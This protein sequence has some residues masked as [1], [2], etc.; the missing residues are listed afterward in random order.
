MANWKDTI[1]L[2]DELGSRTDQIAPEVRSQFPEESEALGAWGSR[3]GLVG[4]AE[5]VNDESA[6]LVH[7]FTPTRHELGV[8]AR[9]YLKVAFDIETWWESCNQVG[10]DETR[11]HAFAGRRLET[12]RSM[13][14]D[15]V[16]EQSEA[17]IEVPAHVDQ[18]DRI[19]L[20]AEPLPR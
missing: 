1:L 6:R 18:N 7:D 14:G 20:E 15:A 10:S 9:H 12:L 17:R 19:A 13:L 11:E 4:L 2:A 5:G 3:L 16:F 8:L